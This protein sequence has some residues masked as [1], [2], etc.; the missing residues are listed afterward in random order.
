V[1]LR[2]AKVKLKNGCSLSRVCE[3]RT[4]NE[5]ISASGLGIRPRIKVRQPLV[6]ITKD[7]T[8]GGRNM[9]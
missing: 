6:A 3:S 8:N 1:H 2:H 9:L 4:N 5:T 7:N